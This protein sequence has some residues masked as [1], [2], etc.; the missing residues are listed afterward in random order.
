MIAEAI[1]G[2]GDLAH[3]YYSKINPSAREII[4]D[5]NRTE[6]YVYAQTIAG[7][8]APTFGEAKNSW[9]TGT[10]AWNYVAITQWILG[11]RPGYYGL[12]IS[13]VLPSDWD[14]VYVERKY[15]G[16]TYKIDIQKEAGREKNQLIVNGHQI[17]GN[18]VPLDFLEGR[19]EVVVKVLVS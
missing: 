4:S 14:S 16:A 5:V 8:D 9:L 15:R 2:N 12:V 17:E 7:I 11:I 18:V 19:D 6:P 1:M 10:A 13:P 3:S